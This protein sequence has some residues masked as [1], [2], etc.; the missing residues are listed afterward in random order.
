MNDGSDNRGAAPWPQRAWIMAALLGAMGL[1]FGLLVSRGNRSYADPMPIWRQ[2]SATFLFV[3]GVAAVLVAQKR[4]WSWATIFAVATGLVVV[5][6]GWSTA[7]YNTVRPTLFEWSFLAALFAAL[8]AAPLF[9]TVRDEGGWRFPYRTLHLHAW[10]DAVIGAA[11]LAFVGLSFLVTV[12]LGALLHLIGIDFIQDALKQSWFG[13]ALAGTAFGAATG[14]LR[15]SDRL[16][17]TLL[18][19]VLVVLSILTPVFAAGIAL[20][21]V[22]LPFTGLQPLWETDS[23]TP[24]LL[25]C[26][27]GGV[28]FVNAVIGN[29]R[30]ERT[31]SHILQ[32]A[33]MVLCVTILPLAMIAAVSMGQ[34]IGQ[35]GWTPE[36]LWAAVT[37]L[38]AI[39]YGAAYL[40]SVLTARRDF[41]DRLRP[42]NTRLAIATCGLAIVLAMP[43]IDFGAIA[44]RSQVARLEAGRVAPEEFDYW[45]LKENFGPAGRGALQKLRASKDVRVAMAARASDQADNRYQVRDAALARSRIDPVRRNLR[46]ADG[47]QPSDALVTAMAR[48]GICTRSRCVAVVLGDTRYAVVGNRF[49]GGSID[50][51]IVDV[52]Q[53]ENDLDT[54]LERDRDSK[55]VLV[56]GARV[57]VRSVERRQVFVDGKPMGEPFE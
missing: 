55:D 33:A 15:E 47:A 37:V 21:L 30:D 36:R 45:A 39:A 44:T 40:A 22:A 28:V 13:W 17:A 9:Q 23:A 20:F 2:L 29:G 4:R 38:V 7:Q 3:T 18:K 32:G 24:I 51:V 25:V 16:L 27:A 5:G 54:A 34:R 46:M 31:G 11:S 12:L 50:R 42:L 56:S 10:T 26:A 1:A 35:Y 48:Q 57:E 6:V 14:V 53:P 52:A 49:E 8:L 41:D 43:F 19:V